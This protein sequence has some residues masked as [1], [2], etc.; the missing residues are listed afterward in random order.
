MVALA[1]KAARDATRQK[2]TSLQK[3]GKMA[4]E[5]Q[6]KTRPPQREVKDRQVLKF[7]FQECLILTDQ[8]FCVNG[9]WMD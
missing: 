2:H 3:I 1:S 8:K 5:C 9:W 6:A 7:L 4:K